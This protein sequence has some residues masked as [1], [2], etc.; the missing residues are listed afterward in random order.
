MKARVLEPALAVAAL[1]GVV[2]GA[3]AL[4]I[5]VLGHTPDA[6][7]RTVLWLSIVA[8]VAVA[9]VYPR[10]HGR[11]ERAARRMLR[12][13][14]PSLGDPVRLFSGRLSRAIPLEELLLQTAEMLR[15]ALSLQAAEIWTGAGGELERTVS[16]PERGPARLSLA[17]EQPVVAREGV[18][19][20]GFA[21]V[22][23]GPLLDGREGALLRVAPAVR[24]GELLG[25]IVVERAPDGEPFDDREDQMLGELARQVALALHN[26]RLDSALQASL[27]ALRRQAD[28]LRASRARIVASADAERR[29]IERDLHDG[30]Q[31]RLVALMLRLEEARELATTDPRS[32]AGVIGE[33]K[34]EVERALDEVR[35]LAHG[36]YP[37]LLAGSGLVDAL[38]AAAGAA[39]IACRVEGQGIERY[40]PEVEAA[41]YFCCL[42]ALQN[43]SKHAGEDARASI[44]LSDGMGTL[45]FAVSDDGV[46]FDPEH[47]AGGVGLT[48]M[49]D[50]VGAI[51]GTLDVESTPG[52]GASVRGTIPL[53]RLPRRGRSGPLSRDGEPPPPI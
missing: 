2:G 13:Q 15:R 9:L 19:G 6:R 5:L 22:W 10:V 18:A 50:R 46:G 31:Q 51:G 35:D 41:V 39:R 20:E 53:S 21:R 23:L 1:L 33:L 38:S 12:A 44:S 3:Y 11:M 52:S 43:A 49:R 34:R 25:L 32:V 28:E 7:E 16:D 30:A 40:A 8:T 42:E 27:E 29:R 37:P 17:T 26:A 36:I 47:V 4:L 45:V 24:S 48:S 14:G